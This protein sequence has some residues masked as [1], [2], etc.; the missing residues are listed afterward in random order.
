[1]QILTGTP[2][3]PAY[4]FKPVLL[5]VTFIVIDHVHSNIVT[6]KDYV[7]IPAMIPIARLAMLSNTPSIFRIKDTAIFF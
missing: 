6:I 4:L 5:V 2:V 3:T 1:M 7:V